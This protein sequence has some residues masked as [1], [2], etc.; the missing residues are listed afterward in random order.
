M[1][2]EK[3]QQR[4]DNILSARSA[5]ATEPGRLVEAA[6]GAPS[7]PLFSAFV[8]E[9]VARASDMAARFMEIANREGLD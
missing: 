6:A 4:L 1:A 2:D 7:R 9:H 8:D 5:K 3:L